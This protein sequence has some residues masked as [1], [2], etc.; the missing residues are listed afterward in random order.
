MNPECQQDT[1]E[2]YTAKIVSPEA[3]KKHMNL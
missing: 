2:V 1:T 3:K